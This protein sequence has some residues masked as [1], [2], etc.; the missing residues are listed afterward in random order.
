MCSNDDFKNYGGQE[1]IDWNRTTPTFC[2]WHV[3][4]DIQIWNNPTRMDEL[5]ETALLYP[6]SMELE[7][8][9]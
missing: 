3:W 4:I 5:I 9:H 1:Q 6:F 2:Q 8:G 7:R